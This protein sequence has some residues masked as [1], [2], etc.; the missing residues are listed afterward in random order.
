MINQTVSVKISNIFYEGGDLFNKI[1]DSFHN[2]Q[3]GRVFSI[4]TTRLPFN[5]KYGHPMY[6]IFVYF[7][8]WYDTPAAENIQSRILAKKKCKFMYD[9]P[10]P[11]F[12]LLDENKSRKLS[13]NELQ[14][15]KNDTEYYENELAAQLQKEQ[16]VE[17]VYI[18]Q[19]FKQNEMIQRLQDICIQNGL[20]L[21]FWDAK[22]P[23]AVEETAYELSAA[24]TALECSAALFSDEETDEETDA[25]A[26]E[27][28]ESVLEEE[29]IWS[30]DFI[31]VPYYEN[32]EDYVQPFPNYRSC[33]FMANEEELFCGEC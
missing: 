14:M 27:C 31:P 33:L 21:P 9:A 16:D 15:L 26:H 11:W 24:Q 5:K 12:W 30:K 1:C 32:D 18:S 23:P 8:V 6:H 17:D 10:E 2:Q 29:D 20:D 22:N 4:T 28:V 19:L 25:L 13:K 3:I 7:S